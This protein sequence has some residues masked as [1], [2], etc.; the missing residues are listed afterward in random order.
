MKGICLHKLFLHIFLKEYQ[1]ETG[2]TLS[3]EKQK[4]VA[5]EFENAAAEVL[6][7][8]TKR[9]LDEHDAQT[10]VLGGGVAANTHIRRMFTE[11][12]AREYPERRLYLPEPRLT[13]DNAVMI[14]LAAHARMTFGG[15]RDPATIIADGNL[16]LHNG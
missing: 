10:L 1:K 11:L 5:L 9:A 16:S 4:E 13:T 12:F 7:A 14:A 15:P 6:V 3:P 2:Q 8:K